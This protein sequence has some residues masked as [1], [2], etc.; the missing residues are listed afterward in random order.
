MTKP[1]T[2]LQR[3]AV[4]KVLKLNRPI[5]ATAARFDISE[6]TLRNWMDR[7]ADE[8]RNKPRAEY[9]ITIEGGPTRYLKETI[10]G[11]WMIKDDNYR[12]IRAVTSAMAGMRWIDQERRGE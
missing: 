11:R 1:L 7:Y 2:S 9:T 3:K 5:K 4:E 6:T 8:E 12:N 10:A